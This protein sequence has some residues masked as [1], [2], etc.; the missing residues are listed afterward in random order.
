[1][2]VVISACVVIAS[3]VD[4]GP[5][6]ASGVVIVVAVLAVAPVTFAVVNVSFGA[7]HVAFT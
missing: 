3:F 2:L 5:G 6:V 7:I 1:M 4:A